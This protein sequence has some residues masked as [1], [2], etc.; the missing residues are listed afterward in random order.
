MWL[1]DAV[2]WYG[3]NKIVDDQIALLVMGLLAGK[4]LKGRMSPFNVCIEILGIGITLM[5]S[6]I[7][8]EYF[9]GYILAP[10]WEYSRMLLIGYLPGRII[11]W[12]GG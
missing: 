8:N 11:E 6:Y 2:D 9:E 4:C 7:M 10:F 3:E 1:V 12:V 5:L